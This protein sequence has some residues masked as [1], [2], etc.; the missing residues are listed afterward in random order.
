MGESSLKSSAS[1]MINDPMHLKVHK[2]HQPADS[3]YK[4]NDLFPA[5][6]RL[7]IPCDGYFQSPCMRLHLGVR[8]QTL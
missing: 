5:H 4:L 1:V 7:L 8:Q 6:A 2:L 3:L